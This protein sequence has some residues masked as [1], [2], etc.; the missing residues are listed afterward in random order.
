MFVRIRSIFVF[1]L[2]VSSFG[3]VS[4]AC[5]VYEGADTKTWEKQ[6]REE[7]RKALA[8]YVPIYHENGELR[9]VVPSLYADMPF[10]H[11]RRDAGVLTSLVD[12]VAGA[13]DF[14][15]SGA[16]FERPVFLIVDLAEPAAPNSRLD[17][18]SKTEDGSWVFHELRPGLL[19]QALVSKDGAKALVP[20]SHFS[21]HALSEAFDNPLDGDETILP[22]VI[23]DPVSI[24]GGVSYFCPTEIL[25]ANYGESYLNGDVDEPKTREAKVSFFKSGEQRK[26]EDDSERQ[27]II[28]DVLWYMFSQHGVHTVVPRNVE[29]KAAFDEMRESEDR[30]VEALGYADSAEFAVDNVTKYMD[31]RIEKSRNLQ[32]VYRSLEGAYLGR[33]ENYK[34]TTLLN[35]KK[36]SKEF[37]GSIGDILGLVG[38][39]ISAVDV[40]INFKQAWDSKRSAV[41]FFLDKTRDYTIGTEEIALFESVIEGTQLYQDSAFRAALIGVKEKHENLMQGEKDGLLTSVQSAEAD[42]VFWDE[43]QWISAAIT[44]TEGTLLALKFIVGGA[45]VAKFT[46]IVGW[47][48]LIYELYVGYSRQTNDQAFLCV[49][50]TIYEQIRLSNYGG[51]SVSFGD[52]TYFEYMARKAMYAHGADYI[53]EDYYAPVSLYESGSMFLHDFNYDDL[54]GAPLLKSHD[55]AIETLVLAKPKI[56][57]HEA[58]IEVMKDIHEAALDS[59]ELEGDECYVETGSGWYCSDNP[60][61][62][63]QDDGVGSRV[64]KCCSGRVEEIEVCSDGCHIAGDYKHDHC[65]EDSFIIDCNGSR[66]AVYNNDGGEKCA[67][68]SV[69]HPVDKGSPDWGFMDPQYPS[70]L[71]L[72]WSVSC[73][74]P[75][76]LPVSCRVTFTENDVLGRA[77]AGCTAQRCETG[78]EGEL[79]NQLRCQDERGTEWRFGHMIYGS[80]INVGVGEWLEVGTKIGLVGNSG[81]TVGST[82]CHLHV[83]TRVGNVAYD[84]EYCLNGVYASTLCDGGVCSSEC[85]NGV[86]EASEVC[87]GEAFVSGRACKN[88]MLISEER[89]GKPQYRSGS[90]SCTNM[91]DFDLSGCVEPLPPDPPKIVVDGVDRTNGTINASSGMQLRVDVH[92]G[93]DPDVPLDKTTLHCGLQNASFDPSSSPESTKYVSSLDDKINRISYLRLNLPVNGRSVLYCRVYDEYGVPHEGSTADL[94]VLTEQSSPCIDNDNQCPAGCDVSNDS[95]CTAAVQCS[96]G[97]CCDSSTGMYLS[98]S[99][100]CEQLGEQYTCPDGTSSGDGIFV[101]V[102]ERFCSGTSADCNGGTASREE[103]YKQCS[104]TQACEIGQASC[105]ELCVADGVCHSACNASNDP[106][107]MADPCLN[108]SCSPCSMCDAGNCVPDQTADGAICAANSVCLNGTCVTSRPSYVV[109]GCTG[110]NYDDTCTG[111]SGPCE[112][113]ITEGGFTAVNAQGCTGQT[114]FDRFPTRGH[115]GFVIMF[116]RSSQT[117]YVVWEFPQTLSGNYRIFIDVPS[118]TGLTPSGGCQSWNLVNDAQFNLKSGTTTLSTTTVD[119][120]H[121]EGTSKQ[122]F[123]GDMTAV[124]AITLGNT[125]AQ[126]SCGVFLLDRIRAE[127]F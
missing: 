119:F 2:F 72:D 32:R 78:G 13:W 47:A 46:N 67:S 126:S 54:Q 104:T 111:S 88:E 110:S 106:D 81:T 31:I 102:E 6:A 55:S 87:D 18:W 40:V 3:A 118:T 39:S 113:C 122:L 60:S 76:F 71:G 124:T 37:F 9:G 96:S 117:A 23:N 68:E 95:D 53:K 109:D 15:P 12:G 24:V 21:V 121:D 92:F 115:N 62:L 11:R 51:E 44:A 79:G 34:Y 90:L 38:F 4:S 58:F 120:A 99:V 84:H 108:V 125:S 101:E 56:Q 116:A 20:L 52:E 17:V 77:G 74:T 19:S 33:G 114:C 123:D 27:K 83:E 127:P 63:F 45:R 29:S 1:L 42:S 98:S 25:K 41:N 107:C 35:I 26:I 57:I 50:A 65:N 75:I 30:F 28:E 59:G 69:F 100:V 14:G 103:P 105:R 97:A 94:I 86:L 7:K 89:G 91:C 22:R 93:S 8:T 5:T 85:G 73:D 16:S 10:E 66:K 80:V 112:G 49:A 43:F 70:H 48:L 61:L 82:G 36:H 64:V